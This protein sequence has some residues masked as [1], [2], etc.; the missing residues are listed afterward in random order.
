VVSVP[1]PVG[2]GKTTL[3]VQY[4]SATER[5]VAWVSLSAAD[6][7]SGLVLVEIAMAL[8]RIAPVEPRVLRRLG[9]AGQSP[10]ALLPELV[11]PL[12]AYPDL[13][14]VLDDVHLVSSPA[15]ISLISSLSQH[16][17]RGR[18]LVLI[19]R[20]APSV[21]LGRV[22]AR[23]LLVGLGRDDLALGRSEASALV[24]KA[25]VELDA[26][27]SNVL[28]DRVEGWPAGLYL[29]ALSPHDKTDAG[30]AVRD[31]AGDDRDVVF[32]ARFASELN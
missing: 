27:D 8:D 11:T 7:D 3:V 13:V 15:S 5:P 19:S 12:G 25:S 28:Y 2:Y 20:E 10:D 22:R 29:A 16:L 6:D 30:S 21:P 18:R 31:F 9:G 32:L 26:E 4:A 24:E 23:R 14:L 1:A 17:P